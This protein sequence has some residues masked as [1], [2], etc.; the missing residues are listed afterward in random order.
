MADTISLQAFHP[1]RGQGNQPA[2]GAIRCTNLS[3][4]RS[5]GAEPGQAVI[6]YVGSDGS[7]PPEIIPG[8]RV[9]LQVGTGSFWMM[10]ETSRQDVTEG[11]FLREVKLIDFRE[12]LKWD[13]VFA[14]F[15]MVERKLVKGN[16]VRRFWHIYP[17]DFAAGT[18]TYSNHSLRARE[19]LDSIFGFT[20]R[21]NPGGYTIETDW[22]REYHR[23]LNRFPILNLDWRQGERLAAVLG[24]VSEALGLTFTVDHIRSPYA[25]KWARKGEGRLPTFVGNSVFP[26]NS[27]G[28]RRGSTFS[29]GATR[30]RVQ[31]GN[32]RYQ[33]LDVP[34]AADWNRSYDLYFLSE[35][36]FVKD[37][38]ERGSDQLG[39]R[40]NAVLEEDPDQLR[41]WFRA[42]EMA[43]LITLG[44]YALLRSSVRRA[45]EAEQEPLEWKD[46]KGY[47]GQ[48][49][50]DVPVWLYLRD[51]VFRAF[52]PKDFQ[53]QNAGGISVPVSSMTAQTD[54]FA[55]VDH[56]AATG[57][58]TVNVAAA[59]SSNGYAVIQGYAIDAEALATLDPDR[60]NHTEWLKVQDLWQHVPFQLDPSTGEGMPT[61]LFDAPIIKSSDFFVEKDGKTVLKAKPTLTVPNVR[62]CLVMEAEPFFYIK[63]TGHRDTVKHEPNLSGYFV[64]SAATL[65]IWEIPYADGQPVTR[66]AD[67]IANTILST[68]FEYEGG[69]Y[70]VVGSNNTALS[71][72]VD[73]VN[74]TVNEG[75]T[76]EQVDFTKERGRSAFVP[77]RDLD[78]SIQ[79]ESLLPG[80]EQLREEARQF[81]TLAETVG[82]DKGL[83]DRLGAAMRGTP[84]P[85]FVA[86]VDAGETLPVGAVLWKAPTVNAEG[87]VAAET[88]ARAAGEEGAEVFSGVVVRDGEDP[89]DGSVD[90]VMSGDIPV[91]V[92]GPVSVNASLG[93]VVGQHYLI[94]SGDPAV[95]VALQAIEDDSVKLIMAR[96]GSGGSGGGGGRAAWK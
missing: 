30:V 5:W 75:G 39:V 27:D 38:F 13:Y 63:G 56:D 66:K 57:K 70:T 72:M 48:S 91:L 18:K 8:A 22:L 89:N 21:R 35:A 9:N 37:I 61:V 65:A 77:E 17:S 78:R 67:D 90:V 83:R 49:R 96:F 46:Y 23:D 51:I 59:T 25:L 32:N 10:A 69:G 20:K 50:S 54:L 94:E 14:S 73:R 44:E 19:I 31:G 52:R 95:A 33:V 43:R 29:G 84:S 68:P 88:C 79:R 82:K 60:F 86:G 64:S 15:N 24:R 1:P 12:Y 6:R 4:T 81:R 92:K 26:A 62:A 3:L 11:G 40:F 71:P 80:Q 45:G 47:N 93:K 41:G 55:E 58:M 16:M 42:A 2:L 7:L 74:L 28:Q 85:V 53:F 34:L 76:S 87:S 36:A